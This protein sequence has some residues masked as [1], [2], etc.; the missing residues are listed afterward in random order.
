MLSHCGACSRGS[1]ARLVQS[2]SQETALFLAWSA[3]FHAAT[4]PPTGGTRR[5]RRVQRLGCQ[6]RS[7]NASAR[8]SKITSMMLSPRYRGT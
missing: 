5:T 8:R 3:L 7:K 4:P 2:K 6:R 1:T